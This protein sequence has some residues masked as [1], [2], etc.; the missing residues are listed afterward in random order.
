MGF[1][2][3]IDDYFCDT[4]ISDIDPTIRNNP[5]FGHYAFAAD[6]MKGYYKDNL[7]IKGVNRKV[8]NYPD[9]LN[10]YVNCGIIHVM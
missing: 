10:G 6:D 8:L 5:S 7:I 1:I 9:F 4:A 3:D 2:L